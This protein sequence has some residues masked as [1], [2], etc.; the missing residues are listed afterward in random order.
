MNPIGEEF[1]SF[2]QIVLC[3]IAR[4]NS[5]FLIAGR[6][7]VISIQEGHFQKENIEGDKWI[8]TIP[9]FDSKYE[10]QIRMHY[11]YIGFLIKVIFQSSKNSS[12]LFSWIF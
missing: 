2:L 9:K 3:E 11:T 5:E 10:H 6:N 8:I 7:V 4:I 12:C 1:L